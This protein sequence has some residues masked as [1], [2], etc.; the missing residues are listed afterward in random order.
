MQNLNFKTPGAHTSTRRTY[1][2]VSI[3]LLKL[4][5]LLKPRDLYYSIYRNTLATTRLSSNGA[6]VSF[7][8]RLAAD[9]SSPHFFLFLIETIDVDT[10]TVYET[11]L[12]TDK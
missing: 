12:C 7:P 2:C 5:K 1:T 8:L 9:K 11:P 10:G 6:L 3:E 4:L